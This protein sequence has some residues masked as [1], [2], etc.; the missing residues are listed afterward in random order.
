MIFNHS[1]PNGTWKPNRFGVKHVAFEV[2]RTK[3][4]IFFIESNV[5]VLK[6]GMAMHFCQRKSTFHVSSFILSDWLMIMFSSSHIDGAP[7]RWNG[8]TETQHRKWKLFNQIGMTHSDHLMLFRTVI[9][10][11]V[12]QSTVSLYKNASKLSNF[13]YLAPGNLIIGSKKDFRF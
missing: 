4:G 13:D 6:F 5:C 8:K 10:F 2:L 3:Y 12:S 11:N 7:P 1:L 9:C